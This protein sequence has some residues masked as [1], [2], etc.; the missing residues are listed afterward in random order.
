MCFLENRK[1]GQN[2]RKINQK[3]TENPD[4]RGEIG[5]LDQQ[6]RLSPVFRSIRNTA[7]S[8]LTI[9]PTPSP[10]TN[11]SIPPA[12]TASSSA[13]CSFDEAGSARTSLS[14]TSTRQSGRL[15][16]LFY[17]AAI[18]RA[19][20]AGGGGP[21]CPFPDD[22]RFGTIPEAITNDEELD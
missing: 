11:D 14:S 1:T 6:I 13:N 5:S 8:K 4:F 17:N 21:E 7:S 18:G 10:R 20:S 9:L 16:G 15:Q 22:L 12:A 2:W 19:K 3:I